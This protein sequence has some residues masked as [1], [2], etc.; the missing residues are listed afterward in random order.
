MGKGNDKN[1]LSGQPSSGLRFD[2][3][4]FSMHSISTTHSTTRF[5]ANN[6]ITEKIL[7]LEIS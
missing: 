4:T 2:P 7:V 5:S 3:G 1:P 6:L